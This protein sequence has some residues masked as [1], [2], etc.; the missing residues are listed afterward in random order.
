MQDVE[1]LTFPHLMN[2]ALKA[3]QKIIRNYFKNNPGYHESVQDLETTYATL[4]TKIW[5]NPAELS[6]IAGFNLDFIKAT[7]DTWK[8]IYFESDTTGTALI[9][10]IKE[11]KRFV[12]PEWNSNPYFN[13]IKHSYLLAEKLSKQII[14][15]TDMNA[16]MRK[17]INFCSG[18]IM[19]AL[20]PSN[21]LFT[22]PEALKLAAET[23]GKSLSDG[24]KN[25]VR[26]L[27]KGQVT[28]TDETAFTVGE[29]L[30]LTKG[31][32]IFQNELIQLIQYTPVTK[33]VF[34][35]PLVIVPPCINKYYILDLQPENSFVK[36]LVESGLTVFIISWR[37]PKAGMS[38][39]SFDDYVKKGVLQAI[40][41]A[42]N[43]SKSK[44]VNTL[45]YC[46][47][48]TLL[49]V[50]CSILSANQKENPVNSVS[51]L[52][53]MVDFSDVGPM[54]DM[55]N[56]ELIEK[57]E[58][59]ELF[60]DGI[61]SGHNMEAAFNLIR[62]NDLIWNYYIRNYLKGEKPSAFDVMYWSNDNT[63]LPGD[64]YR[65][66]MR[67]IVFE[68]QLKN[69]NA[70]TICHTQIDMELIKFPVFVIGLKD[71]TISPAKTTF[72]TTELVRGPVEFILG[73]SGHVM[74]AINSPAKNKYGHYLS[75]KLNVGFD[76]WRKTAKHIEGS[77][78]TSWL[79]RIT[80]LSGKEIPAVLKA[81]NETYK[82]IESAPGK[83]VK[84]K[85]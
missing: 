10:P 34:E 46:V 18:Q 70:L 28:Q 20:S 43:I 57:I 42:K 75:G 83:Y 27:E 85:C 45:G 5:M 53:T 61:L 74:G 80:K 26:D 6:K 22:N 72:K 11:D 24:I 54:G 29:N 79:E 39:L 59:G 63:N 67:N 15:E 69:K 71:D 47:G 82:A 66:Y 44:K 1:N 73:E 52:A 33:N 36:F 3:N 60:T 2:C 65:Y 78:W 7:Q 23:K 41:V 35:V 56:E 62:A 30:G 68:N 21:F 55:I 4:F 51:L 38:H 16:A 32:V 13:F 40:E 49:S 64:M 8:K 50:A 48:G 9:E 58:R 76:E 84:E 81:G 19:D 77:W 31:T 14:D 25:L 17:K 37:N 12:A